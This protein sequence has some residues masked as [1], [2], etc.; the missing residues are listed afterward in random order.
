MTS[1]SQNRYKIIPLAVTI[2]TALGRYKKTVTNPP[3]FCS[4]RSIFNPDLRVCDLIKNDTRSWNKELIE[5]LFYAEDAMLIQSISLGSSYSDDLQIWHYNKNGNFSVK[6]AFYLAHQLSAE[7]SGSH[8]GQSSDHAGNRSFIWNAKIP[9]KVK[10]FLWRLHKEAIPTMSTLI[11]R[12]C[13]VKPACSTCGA[14]EE[15]SRH[16]FIDCPFARQLWALSN[17]PLMV[18]RSWPSDVASWLMQV[19]KVV[20]NEQFNWFTMLCWRIWGRR[21]GL[22]MERRLYNP[23]DCISSAGSFFKDFQNV[24][25][26][27]PPILSS[28]CA[29]KPPSKGSVK[30][31]FDAALFGEGNR[32]GLGVITR[33][34]KGDCLLWK[35]AVM[36]DI[37]SPEHGDALAARMAIELHCRDS[38]RWDSLCH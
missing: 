35:S 11:R 37:N 14:V 23:L 4:A 21:N 22:V 27:K 10:I 7:N 2:G 19:R 17:I 24:V 28:R 34:W 31:N 12:R 3:F 26:V 29:W 18:I 38:R 6:S 5:G 8:A 33:D 20:D 9:N 36:P 32:I 16:I 13:M 15:N 1:A 25:A 30:I